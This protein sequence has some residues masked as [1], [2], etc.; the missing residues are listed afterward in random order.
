MSYKLVIFDMD[1]TILD[2]L[3]DLTESVNHALNSEKYPLRSIDE[4]RS[5]VG[6]GIQ[7]LIER[8][9]PH[10]TTRDNIDKVHKA[11]TTYYKKHCTD[12]TKPYRGITELIDKLH[13][14]GIKTAIVSNKADYAVQELCIKYFDGKFDIAVGDQLYYKKKPAPDLVNF[15][16]KELG[17]SE[18]D[19]VYIGDSDVD[20]MTAANS[21]ID[22]ISVDWGFRS[23]EFLLENGANIVVSNVYELSE[24]LLA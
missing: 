19:T 13:N 9:V 6:N 22:C 14:N 17:I 16:R 11:F 7:K 21:N 2:T 15:V 10:G 3:E 1:G 4:I 24:I 5:F 23:R 20:I 18:N 12:K 8:S